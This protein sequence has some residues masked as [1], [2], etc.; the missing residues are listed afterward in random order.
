MT[1]Q[2]YTNPLGKT[3]ALPLPS[4]RRLSFMLYALTHEEMR[5]R[6]IPFSAGLY[7]SGAK[8]LHQSV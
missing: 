3:V 4:E 8:R 1:F 2:E 5:S 7:S 6:V